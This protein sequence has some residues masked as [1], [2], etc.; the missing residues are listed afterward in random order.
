LANSTASAHGADGKAASGQPVARTVEL[1]VD[2]GD[3]AQKRFSGIAWKESM[4]V[5]DVLQAAKNRPHGISLTSRG[6]GETLI[7]TKID[8]L[9]NQGG[10]QSDNNWIFSVDGHQG[11]ESSGVAKVKPGDRVLWKFG[12][13]E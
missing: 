5:F 2:Y 3:G 12:P 7:I 4:T 11:D 6:S 9:A 13:Y 10:G 8:D 1:V